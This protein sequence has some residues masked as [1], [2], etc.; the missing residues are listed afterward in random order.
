ML[1]IL[2]AESLSVIKLWIDA[3]FA[4]HPDCKGDTGAMMYMG[5]GSIME[6]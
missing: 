2:R 6:L 5:S 1:L 4:S 3:Y